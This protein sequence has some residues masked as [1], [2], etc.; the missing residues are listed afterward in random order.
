MKKTLTICLFS[1]SS[2]FLVGC[3]DIWFCALPIPTSS[4]FE[5]IKN[6]DISVERVRRV[7]N[8][9]DINY[10]DED[11]NTFLHVVSSIEMAELLL[12]KGL[13]VRER[14]SRGEIALYTAIKR[15]HYDVALFLT[16]KG[17]YGFAVTNEGEDDHPLNLAKQHLR[18][19]NLSPEET[20]L[21]EALIKQIQENDIHY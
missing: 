10:K 8:G 3:E 17:S 21:L 7:I 19:K 5:D 20:K 9:D 13:S 15:R 6:N 11:G 2:L 12:E 14:N 18:D 4:F 1:L 16:K